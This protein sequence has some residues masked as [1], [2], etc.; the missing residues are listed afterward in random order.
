MGIN[1]RPFLRSISNNVYSGRLGLMEWTRFGNCSRDV[2]R[3]NWRFYWNVFEHLFSSSQCVAEVACAKVCTTAET[4]MDDTC[5]Q[6]HCATL[7]AHFT[8]VQRTRYTRRQKIAGKLR[9]TD[10]LRNVGRALI[11]NVTSRSWHIRDSAD[12]RSNFILPGVSVTSLDQETEARRICE[13]WFLE[14]P[15]STAPWRL[16][17]L[18][19]AH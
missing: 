4:R 14:I 7:W 2:S 8:C 3:N 5:P 16:A 11:I 6:S 18:I 12:L 9:S 17:L 19:A 13:K 1:R 10:T 15:L